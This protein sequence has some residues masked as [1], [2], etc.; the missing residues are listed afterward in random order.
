MAK[1]KTPAPEA[2]PSPDIIL[3]QKLG[4]DK[5]AI[6]NDVS[7]DDLK[8]LV[9]ILKLKD[10]KLNRALHAL[11]LDIEASRKAA[12]DILTANPIQSFLGLYEEGQWDKIK[13]EVGDTKQYLQ[14]NDNPSLLAQYIRWTL[15]KGPMRLIAEQLGGRFAVY[16]VYNY[17]KLSHEE[18]QQVLTNIRVVLSAE[19]L[20]PPAVE[21]KPA[22]STPVPPEVPP[23]PP[24][25]NQL[26]DWRKPYEVLLEALKEQVRLLEQ[27]KGVLVTT[28]QQLREKLSLQ[29]K[30][31]E[32]AQ[33]AL[34]EAQK[35]LDETR[36]ELDKTRQ[37]VLSQTTQIKT[38]RQ[39]LVARG[40]EQTKHLQ[41]KREEITRL[42]R[43]VTQLTKQ[44]ETSREEYL[45]QLKRATELRQLVERSEGEIKLL[46]GNLDGLQEKNSTLS[47][48][49]PQQ[50]QKIA[51]LQ[52]ML[53]ERDQ[54]IAR[55]QREQLKQDVN[56]FIRQLRNPEREPT[57][58]ELKKGTKSFLKA[59][60]EDKAEVKKGDWRIKVLS[61]LLGYKEG[62]SKDGTQLIKNILQKIQNMDT[63]KLEYNLEKFAT[64]LIEIRELSKT[65]G[66]TPE[67]SLKVIKKLEETPA[68]PPEPE[69][70]PPEPGILN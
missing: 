11:N 66:I 20:K 22:P 51:Q 24:P 2:P 13:G 34:E 31:L 52:K 50:N 18:Q 8:Q 62:V 3:R 53:Q 32:E 23:P 68:P 33:K 5:V 56:I 44:L 27:E 47:N 65:T 10:R 64:Q 15:K 58:D 6:E 43:E 63:K 37:L 69:R 19:T 21:L 1:Q 38:E 46:Q 45:A 55:L 48:T 30:A 16:V 25:K 39:K 28:N 49:V 40:V 59:A 4:L 42:T 57:P 54:V 41:T 9:G 7:L 26:D 60:H 29:Q 67:S 35:T 12:I 36:A 17:K 70:K 14:D 61:I